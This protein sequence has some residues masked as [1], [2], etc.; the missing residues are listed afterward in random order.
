MPSVGMKIY[1]VFFKLLLR[2]RLQS[3]ANAANA[4]DSEGGG[5]D[6]EVSCR[7]DEATAPANP[8]F[9]APDGVASKDIHIDPNAALSVRIFLPTVELISRYYSCASVLTF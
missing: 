7:V 8:A 9:S 6:F 3:L 2:H 5:G 4:A 1:A